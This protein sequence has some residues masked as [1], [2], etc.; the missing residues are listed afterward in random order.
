MV[1]GDPAPQAAQEPG[2]TTNAAKPAHHHAHHAKAAETNYT[3]KYAA[4]VQTVSGTLSMVD[5]GT[6]VL[7]VTDSDGTPF[8]IKITKGTRIRVNGKK[9]SLDDLSGQT[10]QQVSVKYHDRL[11]N[12]LVAQSVELGGG[13]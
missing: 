13:Q 4:G 8:N 6:K 2:T 7:V 10:N 12:G 11:N 3:A 5:S 1:F 9:G